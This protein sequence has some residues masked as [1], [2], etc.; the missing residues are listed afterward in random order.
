MVLRPV[1]PIGAA[2]PTAASVADIDSGDEADC[3]KVQDS[4]DE[5]EYEVECNAM[6]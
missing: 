1:L 5:L 6:S 2:V 3:I 4:T